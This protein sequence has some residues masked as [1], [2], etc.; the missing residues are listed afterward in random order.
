MDH[1]F[2]RKRDTIHSAYQPSYQQLEDTIETLQRELKK[3]KE[4]EQLE[5]EKVNKEQEKESCRLVCELEPPIR[6]FVREQVKK[7][8][9]LSTYEA[10]YKATKDQLL[11]FLGALQEDPFCCFEWAFDNPNDQYSFWITKAA[12]KGYTAAYCY[13]GVMYRE[14]GDLEKALFWYEKAALE[15]MYMAFVNL[16]IY[17]YDWK[18][19]WNKAFFYAQ[20][21][22][23]HPDCNGKG[24]Y[25]MGQC[26]EDGIGCT[27]DLS[28]ALR[29]YEK[30]KQMN[31]E[32]S[33]VHWNA[34]V[35]AM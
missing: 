29:W 5:L 1:A 18:K 25:Y 11:L 15:N 7:Y 26:Y 14:H 27:K 21:C 31:H 4:K 33:T 8:G 22:V 23:Q 6:G 17:W 2:E 20:K 10:Q 24:F 12:E 3:A 34:L 19:D 16:H 13:L 35:A 28:L 9:L 32:M 30:G